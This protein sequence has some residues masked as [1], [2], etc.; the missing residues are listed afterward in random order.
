M[1]KVKKKLTMCKR[2]SIRDEY[3]TKRRA[4]II[5]SHYDIIQWEERFHKST[6]R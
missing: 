6:L 4:P 5:I 1:K 2:V 3:A